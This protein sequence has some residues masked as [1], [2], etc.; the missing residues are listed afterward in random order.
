MNEK[1]FCFQCEQTVSGTGCIGEAGVCGKKAETAKLQDKLTGALITLAT[2]LTHD[3]SKI[4]DKTNSLII[5]GLLQ[6]LQTLTL[7]T[8]QFQNLQKKLKKKLKD[9]QKAANFV[10][11]FFLA[12]KYLIQN[13]YGNKKM[14][15]VP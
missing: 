6:Q 11:L 1:M 10:K 4:T 13:F 5:E 15:L 3:H 2:A 14:I 8:K 9:V 7:T 12:T